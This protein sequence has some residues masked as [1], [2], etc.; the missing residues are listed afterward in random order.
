MRTKSESSVLM[1]ATGQSSAKSQTKPMTVMS[2]PHP[3]LKSSRGRVLWPDRPPMPSHTK[4]GAPRDDEQDN[5]SSNRTRHRTSS[6][7]SVTSIETIRLK[8]ETRAAD[9]LLKPKLPIDN[10]TPTTR[11]T[12]KRTHS[13]T[14]SEVDADDSGALQTGPRVRQRRDSNSS[15]NAALT[16]LDAQLRGSVEMPTGVSSA[17]KRL[18]EKFPPPAGVSDVP[19]ERRSSLLTKPSSPVIH[20]SKT[21]NITGSPTPV[22]FPSKPTTAAPN[23]ELLKVEPLQ[24]IFPNTATKRT[25]IRRPIPGARLTQFNCYELRPSEFDL[26]VTFPSS[27]RSNFEVWD[28][29]DELFLVGPLSL[30]LTLKESAKW[31]GLPVSHPD[32]YVQELHCTSRAVVDSP[33]Y[34]YNATSSAETHKYSVSYEGA[35]M[36]SPTGKELPVDPKRGIAIDMMWARTYTPEPYGPGR[37]GWE[38]QF[39]VPIA[40]RL[41]EK[42]ETR[43]FRV[44]ALVS[45]WGETLPAQVATMSVSHLMREREMVRR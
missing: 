34:P 43:A 4:H 2:A 3:L 41:F 14:S 20:N 1:N 44:E 37:R 28:Q 38:L 31:D 5:S 22:A 40:T 18:R 7:T 25:A 21:E 8:V 13:A 32:A 27:S 30:H 42:R 12:R 29:E 23:A 35:K 19:R 39:F 15:A 6:V 9:A 33:S 16:A 11:G 36:R 24:P 10:A 17:L 45:V 26:A